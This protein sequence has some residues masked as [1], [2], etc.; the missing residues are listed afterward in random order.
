[1]ESLP[2]SEN[3]L[4]NSNNDSKKYKCIQSNPNELYDMIDSLKEEY[5]SIIQ[6]NINTENLD[7]EAKLLFLKKMRNPQTKSEALTSKESY[8]YRIRVK[9]NTK[10]I[11]NIAPP[12]DRISGKK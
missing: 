7:K 4:I 10:D 8:Y 11:T 6:F 3:H 5:K 12:N 9:F 2:P 1:M